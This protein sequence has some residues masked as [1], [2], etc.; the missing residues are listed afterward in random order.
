MYITKEHIFKDKCR[1][2]TGTVVILSV[3][4]PATHRSVTSC[5]N[6]PFATKVIPPGPEDDIFKTCKSSHHLIRPTSKPMK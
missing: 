3:L 6:I 1:N 4:L 2:K 5:A